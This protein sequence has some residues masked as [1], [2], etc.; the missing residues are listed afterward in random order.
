MAAPTLENVTALLDE[1][2]VTLL[3]DSISYTPAGGTAT[4][5]KA[6][7]DYSEQARDFG[8]SAS[9]VQEMMFEIRIVDA[10]VRPDHAVRIALPKLPGAVWQ[11][12]DVRLS[13]SGTMWRFGL[14]QVPNA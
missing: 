14:K 8:W 11:P 2:T 5:L 12:R 13:S 7:V 10:P 9:T 6:F 4:P 1:K 3:G